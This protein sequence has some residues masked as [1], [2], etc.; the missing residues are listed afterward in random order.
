MLH[1][2]LISLKSKKFPFSQNMDLL[3]FK[4]K[5]FFLICQKHP[6]IIFNFFH[7]ILTIL[8]TYLHSINFWGPFWVFCDFLKMLTPF[9]RWLFIKNVLNILK[10]YIQYKPYLMSPR[11]KKTKLFSKTSGISGF[12]YTFFWS[13]YAKIDHFHI[14]KSRGL[15]IQCRLGGNC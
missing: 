6:K 10:L 7:I 2:F 12:W 14:L 8:V 3:F 1:S 4:D 15:K 5:D 9:F 13:I 11:M